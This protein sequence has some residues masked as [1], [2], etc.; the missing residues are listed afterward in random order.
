[1][2]KRFEFSLQ[3]EQRFS[4]ASFRTLD[5]SFYPKRILNFHLPIYTFWFTPSD[6][7]TKLKNTRKSWHIFLYSTAVLIMKN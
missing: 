6:C 3:N 1:M 4:V 5:R 2:V 7:I